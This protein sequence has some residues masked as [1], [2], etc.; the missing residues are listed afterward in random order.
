MTN[1]V[2]LIEALNKCG[3]FIIRKRGDKFK[4]TIIAT[5]SGAKGNT[6]QESVVKCLDLHNKR[7][8]K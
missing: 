5:S 8:K 6:M 4:T 2:V 7:K 3:D 1:D